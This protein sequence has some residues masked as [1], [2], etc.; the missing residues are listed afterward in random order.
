MKE[1]KEEHFNDSNDIAIVGMSCRF[2]GASTIDDFWRNLR[3]G[4]ESIRFFSDEEMKQ[5][6]VD[7]AELLA[8]DFVKAGA[9]IED[10]ECFDAAFFGFSPRE[11]RSLDP[12]HR[13]FLECAYQAFD[14]AGCDTETFPGLI[15]VYAGTSMSSYL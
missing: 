9:R 13:V 5:F 3:D 2:P 7:S 12:Q 14:D 11:A 10:S 15:G 6:G 4:I 8:T 1:L